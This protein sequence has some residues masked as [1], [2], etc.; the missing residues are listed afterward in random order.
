MWWAN[1]WM[2]LWP[3]FDC[4][5]VTWNLL[6]QSA[7]AALREAHQ[8]GMDIIVKEGMANGRLTQRNPAASFSGDIACARWRHLRAYDVNMQ[9]I[10]WDCIPSNC[11]ACTEFQCFSTL[12]VCISQYCRVLGM[13]FTN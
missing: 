11:T 5:Q 7:G 4:V 10:F 9:Q 8:A 3:L 12:R 13:Y 1:P 6:E 2:E